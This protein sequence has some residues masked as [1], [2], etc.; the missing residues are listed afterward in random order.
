[1]FIIDWLSYT[2]S[3]NRPKR[4]IKIKEKGTSPG[5]KIST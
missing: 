5:S 3:K 4:P 2:I 1:M